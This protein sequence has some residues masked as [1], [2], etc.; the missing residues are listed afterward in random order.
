MTNEQA[1][2]ILTNVTEGIA[3]NYQDHITVKR[4][5]VTLTTPAPTPAKAKQPK[6]KK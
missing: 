5:L 2:Q 4:A 3:L 1:I 6:A